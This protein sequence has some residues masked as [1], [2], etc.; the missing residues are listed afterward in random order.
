MKLIILFCLILTGCS[1]KMY[2]VGYGM[3]TYSTCLNKYS[4]KN[5]YIKKTKSRTKCYTRFH[6][7]NP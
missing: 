4:P 6:K 1:P 2:M 7:L 3:R 5:P